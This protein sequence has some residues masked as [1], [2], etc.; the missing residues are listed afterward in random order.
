PVA[1]GSGYVSA[2]CRSTIASSSLFDDAQAPSP[3]TTIINA[4]MLRALVAAIR[5]FT[6]LLRRCGSM[7]RAGGIG[8][9]SVAR[10]F[11]KACASSPTAEDASFSASTAAVWT[12]RRRAVDRWSTTRVGWR[13]AKAHQLLPAG[14][15]LL[16]PDRLHSLGGRERLPGDR[17]MDR[18]PDQS[19][20]VRRRIRGDVGGRYGVRVSR[21]ELP[22]PTTVAVLR[23]A[24]GSPSAAQAPAHLDQGS[25]ERLRGRKTPVQQAGPR[26]H[27]RRRTAQGDRLRDPRF[28]GALRT[29][30]GR[31]GLLS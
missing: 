8:A 16:G 15:H 21:V 22:D 20:G 30:R 31:G 24:A 7:R 10:C 25:D 2:D 1:F 26:R 5:F 18:P 4:L 28:D 6:A 9:T 19:T 3:R 23:A 11:S 14:S 12:G 17:Q 27:Q 13:H 29:S